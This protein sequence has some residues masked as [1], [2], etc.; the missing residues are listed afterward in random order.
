MRAR[1]R[2]DLKLDFKSFVEYL[3]YINARE[4]PEP[5]YTKMKYIE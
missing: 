4:S 3:K 1:G 2:K 5:D